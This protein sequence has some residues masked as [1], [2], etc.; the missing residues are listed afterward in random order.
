[1]C[2]GHYAVDKVQSVSRANVGYVFLVIVCDECNS[3]Q[4]SVRA[5][6][7]PLSQSKCQDRKWQSSGTAKDLSSSCTPNYIYTKNYIRS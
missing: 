1:M 5:W 6:I 7:T 3:D 4:C 2:S